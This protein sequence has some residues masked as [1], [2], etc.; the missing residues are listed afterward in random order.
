MPRAKP[1]RAHTRLLT[2]RLDTDV[3]E[4]ICLEAARLDI[5]A[6]S[7]VRCVISHRA[8]GGDLAA[9][10]MASQAWHCRSASLDGAGPSGA[11][12]PTREPPDA[13]APG[14]A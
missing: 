3:H 5:P 11:A 13:P 2:I 10:I 14:A 1:K 9:Y 6:S 4:A 12:P 8:R 7:L